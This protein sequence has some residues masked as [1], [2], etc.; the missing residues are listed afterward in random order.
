MCGSSRRQVLLASAAVPL[1]ARLPRAL[2][3]VA[4]VGVAMQPR[5]A[6]GADLPPRGPLPEEAAGDVRFLLVH[7]TAS[8]N[9]YAQAEV[10]G[11]LRGFYGLHTGTK[12]W[13]DI[14]YNLSL[15]HI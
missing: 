10:P 12:G 8:A 9:G 4:L 6:W 14:A 2:P 7:H 11:L 3:A 5:A 13:P 15:I 1:L